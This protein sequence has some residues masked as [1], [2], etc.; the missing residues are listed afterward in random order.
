MDPKAR[1]LVLKARLFRFLAAV[2][3]VT[4]LLI[5]IIL[6]M[7]NIEGT[8]L[9]ALTNPFIVV[10]LLVPFL[11]AAVLSLLAARLEREYIRKYLQKKKS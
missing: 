1:R 11:P 8:F 7:Q 3:A 4:G 2:F 10:I 6:Y 9:S 5:F